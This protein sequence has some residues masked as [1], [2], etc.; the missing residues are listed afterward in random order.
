MAEVKHESIFESLFARPAAK[1]CY[2][3]C[4]QSGIDFID[5][6]AWIYERDKKIQVDLWIELM[7]N[8]LSQNIPRLSFRDTFLQLTTSPNKWFRT[9]FF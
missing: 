2:F 9:Y 6:T 4:K 3:D 1:T 5:T 8:W 7:K